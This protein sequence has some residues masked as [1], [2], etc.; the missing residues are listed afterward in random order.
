[1]TLR[2]VLATKNPYKVEEMTAILAR[3]LPQA[4]IVGGLDWP[5]V[6]ETGTT[7]EDNARLKARAVS[8]ATGLA[9]LADDTGLEVDAL[10]G[11]PGVYAARFAGADGD[12]AAN[13]DLLLRRLEGVDDRRA[14]FRTVMLLAHPDGSEIA[15]EGVLEGTITSEERGQRGFG[16]DPLFAVEG[17]T[18]AEMTDDEKNALSHRFAALEALAVALGDRAE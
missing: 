12:H 17:R 4:E 1:M 6:D 14:R 10:D 7:L 8:S 15:A 18:L 9:A 11:A 2:F 3:L 13:R 5:E 16:Y